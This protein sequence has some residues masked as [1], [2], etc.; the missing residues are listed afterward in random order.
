[1]TG[2]ELRKIIADLDMSNAEFSREIDYTRQYIGQLTHREDQAI[3][4]RF[5]RWL[6]SQLPR[7]TRWALAKRKLAERESAR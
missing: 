5:E 7:L 4:R 3:P 1:M 6:Q 2:N